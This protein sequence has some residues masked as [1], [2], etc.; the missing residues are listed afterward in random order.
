MED[1]VITAILGS[2]RRRGNSDALAMEFLRGAGERGLTHRLI[3]PSDLGLSPCDGDGH[4]LKDGNC[5]IRDGMNEL[6]GQVLRARYLLVASPVYFMG[7]PGSLKVFIDRFQAV[8]ARG[9]LLGTFDPDSAERRAGH[10]AFAIITAAIKDKPSMYRPT[11]SIIKAF[12]N[13]TGFNYSGELIA[14]GLEKPDDASG[15][16]DLLKQAYE[17]GTQF[18]G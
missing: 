10:K 16:E 9:A 14:T 6:Y 7:P 8:W 18:A 1:R 2:P 4:C 17:A 11:L 15:R 5:I 3:V 13:V 12:L